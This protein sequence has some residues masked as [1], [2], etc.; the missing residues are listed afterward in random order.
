M[1]V[2]MDYDKTVSNQHICLA[3]YVSKIN[4]ILQI[5]LILLKYNF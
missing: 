1:S 2:E 4:N 5:L 3:P